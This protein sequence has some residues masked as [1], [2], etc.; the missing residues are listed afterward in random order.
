[1]KIYG[2]W[3]GGSS[4]AHPDH[5][6]TEDIEEFFS[7]QQAEHAMEDRGAFGH[8][9]YPC[10]VD[11][12]P[13]EGGHYMHLYKENPYQQDYLTPDYSLE[14]TMSGALKRIRYG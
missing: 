3:Y 1:M 10:I 9:Y 11:L 13:D 12:P 5:Y 14:F 4:Y 2:L 8:S 6:N 7:I